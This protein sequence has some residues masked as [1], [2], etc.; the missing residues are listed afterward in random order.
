MKLKDYFNLP[1]PKWPAIAV[2]GEKV[3]P[4]QAQE[5]IIRT[6]GFHF[7][8]NDE[9]FEDQILEAIGVRKEGWSKNWDDM[10]KADKKYQVLPEV[11]YLRSSRVASAYVGGPNGWIN[12]DGTIFENN[13][14]IGKYPSV[15][16]VYREWQA[17][18]RAFPYLDLQCQLF[19]GEYC[20][21]GIK[22]VVQYNVKGGKVKMSIPK[23]ALSV[24]DKLD[25]SR[26][27]INGRERG[28]TVE[29]FKSA[30]QTTYE[31]L[32]GETE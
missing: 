23:V 31:S 29:F 5:I 14:N 6:G 32:Y 28:C 26:I 15:E 11:N 27:G 18:A 1:L 4:Y 9:E 25:F 3:T 8:T 21:S 22:P 13:K 17:I 19:D 7:F 24:D 12:W 10:E 16:E 30:L 20:E 2:V